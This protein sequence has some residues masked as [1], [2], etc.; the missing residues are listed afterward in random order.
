MGT[1][2]DVVRTSLQGLPSLQPLLTG[3]KGLAGAAL[4]LAVLY[5]LVSKFS[6]GH[7]WFSQKT[8]PLVPT[9]AY[10]VQLNELGQLWRP[11]EAT[12]AINQITATVRTTN[13][14]VVVFIHGWHHNA[15]A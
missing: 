4:T 2:F 5:A 9:D 15:H 13:T 3:L 1:V 11:E 10:V 7:R 14:I 12:E 8:G 6:Y